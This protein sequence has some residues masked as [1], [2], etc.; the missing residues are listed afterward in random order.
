MKRI[1]FSWVSIVLMTFSARFQPLQ[2]FTVTVDSNKSFLSLSHKKAFTANE[3]VTVK[4]ALN[5]ALVFSNELIEWYNMEK[6]HEKVPPGLT[7]TKTGIAAISFDRE[8]F[9]QCKTSADLKRMTG[10]ITKNSFSHFALI[11]N[12]SSS[13]QHCF[14]A[15]TQEGKRCLLF[16]TVINGNSFK[17]EVKSE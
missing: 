4:D 3:A 8:Q 17:V 1:F 5:I 15:E 14:I 9:D 6:R 10:H 12:G 2:Q 16:V 11:R 7:G 13:L